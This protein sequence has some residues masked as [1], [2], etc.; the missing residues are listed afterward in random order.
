MNGNIEKKLTSRNKKT[1][2]HGLE[3]SVTSIISSYTFTLRNIIFIIIIITISL[4]IV[5]PWSVF[6]FFKFFD[7]FEKNFL[8]DNTQILIPI[9]FNYE[10]LTSPPYSITELNNINYLKLNVNYDLYLHVSPVCYSLFNKYD[11]YA[12]KFSLINKQLLSNFVN[13]LKKK[14][15]FK[16]NMEDT[17]NMFPISSN[18]IHQFYSQ[19][20]QSFTINC[21]NS[22]Q[23][24]GI[25]IILD[26]FLNLF[27]L[28]SSD[29][30]LLRYNDKFQIFSNLKLTE[31]KFNNWKQSSILIELN[32]NDILIDN[33]NAHISISKSIHQ[34]LDDF[35]SNSQNSE[36]SLKTLKYYFESVFNKNTFSN[37]LKRY[38]I[39]VYLVG[40][41]FVFITNLILYYLLTFSG[42]YYFNLYIYQKY[43]K[44]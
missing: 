15:N 42:Y 13:D 16:S 6:L 10:N 9:E 39:L 18:V 26:S 40:C 36:G 43:Y 21:E 20:L 8:L 32:N 19:T 5:F 25:Q 1:K 29:S 38:R 24:H 34:S 33:S 44:K 3:D 35:E 4:T 7:I 17:N 2:K 30:Y 27:K 12:I 41:S 31:Q 22:N 37:F 11:K 28:F 14:D 23:K